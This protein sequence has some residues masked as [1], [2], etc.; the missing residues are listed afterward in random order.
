MAPR[1]KQMA[2][3]GI[4]QDS[5]AD[6]KKKVSFFFVYGSPRTPWRPRPIFVGGSSIGRR[7]WR[8]Q[9]D[10]GFSA[11]F[12]EVFLP[13]FVEKLLCFD[14]TQLA[15]H[16]EDLAAK[17]AQALS[18]MPLLREV[19][20][21]CECAFGRFSNSN[22]A[23]S[24]QCC[25]WKDLRMHGAR[26][27]YAQDLVQR[28]LSQRLATQGTLSHAPG[29]GQATKWNA[30]SQLFIKFS[31][32]YTESIILSMLGS[33]KSQSGLL[34]LKKLEQFLLQRR[35]AVPSLCHRK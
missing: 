32:K 15:N 16:V 28:F 3:D 19:W 26:L 9:L 31:H 6:L 11:M 33:A 4:R 20:V 13:G 2:P 24:M 27:S 30:N 14:V 23:L 21:S 18:F 34:L 10:P 1:G 25:S 35:V 22:S 8:G 5:T 7:R 29:V 17:S 12:R